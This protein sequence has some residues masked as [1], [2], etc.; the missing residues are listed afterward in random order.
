MGVADPLFGVGAEG[1]GA[2]D[3]ATAVPLSAAIS[4]SSV[5]IVG[6]REGPAV[7]IA[8]DVYSMYC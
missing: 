1:M 3:G 6:N 8:A 7:A 5:D 4:S 2:E